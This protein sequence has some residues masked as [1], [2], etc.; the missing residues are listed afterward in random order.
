MQ[1]SLAP[2]IERARN[3]LG[4]HH[5]HIAPRSL[6][7]CDSHIIAG[8]TRTRRFAV[9]ASVA[10]VITPT[11]SSPPPCRPDATLSS[12]GPLW[13]DTYP[14]HADNALQNGKSCCICFVIP[15]SAPNRSAK[16]CPS[17]TAAAQVCTFHARDQPR[18]S[19]PRST[20]QI[21]SEIPGR[22]RPDV[23]AEEDVLVETRP[24]PQAC[25]Q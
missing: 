17:C 8:A 9:T 15:M 1:R 14:R 22:L 23:P 13:I 25:W 5:H 3:V 4:P 2:H 11:E 16:G 10:V 12:L 20:C 6:R 18:V 7:C 24:L 21:R 19:P